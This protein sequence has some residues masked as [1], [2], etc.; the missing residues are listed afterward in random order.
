MTET[1]LSSLLKVNNAYN[2]D[3]QK[4]MQGKLPTWKVLDLGMPCG[5]LAKHIDNA[6]NI[7][8][9]QRIL[10][11]AQKGHDTT[12]FLKQLEDLPIKLSQPPSIFQSK[13]AGSVVVI[14]DE[15]DNKNNPIVVPI[16]KQGII[17]D[18][19]SNKCTNLITSIHGRPQKHLELWTEN[20]LNLYSK[21]KTFIHPEQLGTIPSVEMNKGFK[22]ATNVQQKNEPAKS[23]AEKM[24]DL[25]KKNTAI[26]SKSSSNKQ[27]KSK[28]RG[29]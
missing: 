14:L 5:E 2:K 10:T 6:T 21:E 19:K 29:L 18:G 9:S 1:E 23:L 3:L 28:G 17:F 11:K 25:T 8:M 26:L 20:G 4:Y 24:A 22:D 12:M 7:L 13:K 27:Q 16:N 15:K